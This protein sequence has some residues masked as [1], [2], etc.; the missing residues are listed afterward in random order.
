MKIKQF[1]VV[2]S[3]ALFV[4]CSSDLSESE[5]SAMAD[6]AT[7]VS[8]TLVGTDVESMPDEYQIYYIVVAD[9]SRNYF[10]LQKTMYELEDKMLFEIDTMNRY[11]NAK[12]DLI[13]LPDNIED[14]I[15]AGEY[16]P[17]RSP[18][19]T[20]SLE[21]I[22]FYLPEAGEKTIA[23]VAGIYEGEGEAN[24]RL[25]EV[26]KMAKSAFVIKSNVFVGCMH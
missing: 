10:A 26:R 6:S 20:L 17:R 23:L 15:Y 2:L 1:C 13:C 11:Y 5:S 22:N 12:M 7:L 9:T 19:A 24:V 14:E 3:C 25:A 18:S 8:D 21:Y 4:A 16:F